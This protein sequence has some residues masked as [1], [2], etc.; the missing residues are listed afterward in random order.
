[1]LIGA[2][3]S[4]GGGLLKAL[5]RGEER[6]CEAIQIF[7]QSPR[8]W[9]PTGY[10]D[11]DFAAFREAFADSPIRSVVIHM[12]YLVNPATSDRELRR[13]S[14]TSLTHALRVGDGID[15][16]GLV[17]HPGALKGDTREVAK[18]RAIG[19]LTEALA[20]SERC[21]MLLEQTAGSPA[22]LGRGFDE[23]GELIR[24]VGGRTRRVGACLDSCHLHA[25][26]WDVRTPDGVAAMADDFDRTVGLRRLRYLHLNDSRDERG[27]NRDR[28]AG[29][30]EGKI[31]RAGFRAFL[32]EP[33]FQDL[34]AVL[35][36][37]GPDGHG[38]DRREVLLTRRLWREGLRARPRGGAG[39]AGRGRRGARSRAQP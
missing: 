20:E 31:G 28:H 29:I 12:V 14:L 21:P 23:L 25:E 26:G 32:A 18:K 2:H 13:K 19:L 27:S 15:A 35:E 6:R 11:E 16:D 34:P 33:R 39:G 17:I 5:E 3:V 30:G 1:M 22:L 36:T 4:T 9:R 38:P 37:P 24:K 8:M 10:T 7:N